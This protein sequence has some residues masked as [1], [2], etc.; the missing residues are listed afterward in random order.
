[1]GVR[2]RHSGAAEQAVAMGLRP[3]VA[4]WARVG[5]EIAADVTR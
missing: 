2:E 3:R 1:M 5:L 4:R